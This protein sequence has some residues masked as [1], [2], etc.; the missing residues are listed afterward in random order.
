MCCKLKLMCQYFEICVICVSRISFFAGIWRFGNN[1][2]APTNH[3]KPLIN[4]VS[5]F[6]DFDRLTNLALPIV[7]LQ[8]II[9]TTFIIIII[10][11][12]SVCALTDSG[13]CLIYDNTQILYLVY[14]IHKIMLGEMEAHMVV[15]TGSLLVQWCASNAVMN[16]FHRQNSSLSLPTAWSNALW[17][18]VCKRMHLIRSHKFQY[19]LPLTLQKNY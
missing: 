17:S 5:P 6:H 12:Y 11:T 1:W 4:K 14:I 9:T 13:R 19:I 16:E 2:L 18:I 3:T 7:I 10:D 15:E 8:I